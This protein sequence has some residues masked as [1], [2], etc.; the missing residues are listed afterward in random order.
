M[1]IMGKIS[2]NCEKRETTNCCCKLLDIF[3]MYPDIKDHL[4]THFGVTPILEMFE[5]T[6]TCH[7]GVRD[8]Y[9]A[10]ALLHVMSC[11][12]MLCHVMSCY[13][14]LSTADV[15]SS[16]MSFYHSLLYSCS[17]AFSS[18]I[19]LV[20]VPLSSLFFYLLFHYVSPSHFFLS[21]F[22]KSN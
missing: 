7:Q 20:S 5:A 17:Y 6:Q 19:S 10:V 18:T 1:Y 11:Y 3:S 8:S 15:T 12:V 22:Y 4:V 21:A 14:M 9:L 2:S 16:L 13:V